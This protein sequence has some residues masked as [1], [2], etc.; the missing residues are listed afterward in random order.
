MNPP[1]STLSKGIESSVILQA[2]NWNSWRNRQYSFF[3]H[4]ES[5]SA[6][7]RKVGIDAIWLPPCYKSVSPQGYMPLDL[8]DMNSQYGSEDD[9][10]QCIRSF[11]AHDI[12]VYADIVINHR[13][14]EFQNEHGV[15]NVF[16]GKLRW[17]DAAIVS[18][19]TNFHGKGNHSC[20]KLFNSA[21]N[22]DHTQPFVKDDLIEWMLWMKHDIGFGGFRFDFM[23]GIDPKDMKD[24]FSNIDVDVCI[25]EYWDD[26]EY[27]LHNLRY[28]QNAHRQR[29]VDW[30][31][32]SGKHAHA[33]DMTTKGILQEALKNREYWRL[34]DE[35]NQPSGVMGWWKE[36]SVTFLDNH[37]THRD[38]QNHWPFPAEHVIEGYAYILTHPGVPMVYWDDVCDEHM[39]DVLTGLIK[40]R[41]DYGITSNSVVEILVA[42]N[43]QYS[44]VI[45]HKIKLTFGIPSIN[46]HAKNEKN[47]LLFK[48]NGVLIERI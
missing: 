20:F 29:I 23:T 30:I 36:K 11:N 41:K 17:T 43:E 13:C 31:D 9:L 48:L 40:L 3:N 18:N 22:I 14:A 39:R 26:M 10:R 19:D 1:P 42:D 46:H 28:N 21:P 27:D 33:F 2:Y 5:K 8:Y 44:A 6:D 24:Y 37:D 25:G 12:D 7:I 38:S 45:D 4:L 15:Y 35:N 47:D 16:G 34:A 32:R